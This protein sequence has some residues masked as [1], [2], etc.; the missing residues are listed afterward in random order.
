MMIEQQWIVTF[1]PR[2]NQEQKWVVSGE[3]NLVSLCETLRWNGIL[4]YSVTPYEAGSDDDPR[5]ANRHE[6]SQA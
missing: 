1:A 5:A 2:V 4:R 6:G 3:R